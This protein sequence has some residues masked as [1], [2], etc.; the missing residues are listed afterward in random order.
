MKQKKSQ[1][2]CRSFMRRCTRFSNDLAGFRM[3]NEIVT[4]D[5]PVYAEMTILDNSK[6]LMYDFY[7][8]V[9]KTYYEAKCEVIYTD[10]DSLLLEIQTNDV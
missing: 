7:Y 3:Q 9:L 5:K 1:T 4:L 8:N 10:T 2:D 6:I